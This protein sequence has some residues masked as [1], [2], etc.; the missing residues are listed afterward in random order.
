MQSTF[1]NPV[2]TLA[3]KLNHVTHLQVVDRVSE[4]ESDGDLDDVFAAVQA[5]RRI[6]SCAA[7]AE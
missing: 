7:A 5:D 3:E 4:T 1:R 6:A 2:P